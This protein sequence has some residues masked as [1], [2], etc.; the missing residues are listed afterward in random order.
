MS[1]NVT[2]LENKKSVNI[3]GSILSLKQLEEKKNKSKL[4]R[5][6]LK[7]LNFLIEKHNVKR[8]EITNKN[9]QRK[10]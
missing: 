5:T 7:T 8:L 2:Y 3:N 9:N 10:E 4:E 1:V 6:I